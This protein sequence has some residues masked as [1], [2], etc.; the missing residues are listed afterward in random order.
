MKEVASSSTLKTKRHEENKWRW[1][2]YCGVQ[3]QRLKEMQDDRDVK[4]MAIYMSNMTS[5]QQDFFVTE[6]A[7]IV[8]ERK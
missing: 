4:I 6:V 2:I 8:K 7:R 1:E 5:D 3:D